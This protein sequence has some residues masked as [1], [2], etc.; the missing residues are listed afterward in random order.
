M[1]LAPKQTQVFETPATGPPGGTQVWSVIKVT[2]VNLDYIP[3][4][5][6]NAPED[7]C[8]QIE[9]ITHYGL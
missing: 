1:T 3:V 2:C 9:T 5:F 8:L 6:P 4:P 7:L